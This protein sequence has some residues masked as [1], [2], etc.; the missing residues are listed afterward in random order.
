MLGSLGIRRGRFINIFDIDGYH[1]REIWL[2]YSRNMAY[3][4]NILGRILMDNLSRFF[5]I[6]YLW[7]LFKG[8]MVEIW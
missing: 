8:N 2:K 3:G 5:G 6:G 7:I 1:I 4:R